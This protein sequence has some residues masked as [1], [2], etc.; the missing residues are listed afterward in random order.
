MTST[1][2]TPLSLAQGDSFLHTTMLDP[3]AQPLLLDLEREYTE[4]YSSMFDT[5]AS[6]EINRY[7]ADA[8][9]APQGTFLLLLRNGSAIA[10]GAFM[11]IAE[12]TVEIKRVWTDANFRG[13]GFARLVLAE[14]EAEATRRGFT[15]VVLSTGP[16]QPEAVHLYFATGYKPQFDPALDA[17]TIGAHE[18]RKRL[19]PAVSLD[20]H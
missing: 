8:F 4:R 20:G 19:N 17:A 5:P 10:G 1:H 12:N 11:T 13:H 16:R 3:L 6:E 14:L 18:F 7:P 15:D 2:I 9:V